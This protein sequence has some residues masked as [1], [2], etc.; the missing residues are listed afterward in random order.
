MIRPL[1]ISFVSIMSCY[2]HLL[3]TTVRKDRFPETAL[4]RV[5]LCEVIY[6]LRV[7]CSIVFQC[8]DP[9]FSVSLYTAREIFIYLLTYLLT[10]SR[11]SQ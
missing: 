9:A 5:V 7:H 2:D 11:H 6:V 8:F 1:C 3:Y 10:F 4:D